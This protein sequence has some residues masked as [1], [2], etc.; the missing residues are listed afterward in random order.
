VFFSC[1]KEKQKASN[2]EAKNR[3]LEEELQLYKEALGFSND[4]I[5]IIVDSDFN[6]VFK[7]SLVDSK[8]DN[9]NRLIDDIRSGKNRVK[10][11]ECYANVIS[12]SLPNGNKIYN[13]KKDDNQ[14]DEETIQT[15]Q[16]NSI[17]EALLDTQRTF[18]SMLDELNSLKDYSLVVANESKDGLETA[19]VAT[20]R[21]QMLEVSM[22]EAVDSVKILYERSSEIS[23]MISLIE[24]IADQTNLLAL[25]AAI[26][27][28]RAGEY[29]RGFAVVA[30]EVRN[31][32][33][34]TQNATREITVVVNSIQQ[35][36]TKT[37]KSTEATGKI[38][39]ETVGSIT[40]LQERMEKFE[41]NASRTVFEVSHLSDIIFVTL[42]KVDHVIYKNNVYGL[43]HVKDGNFRPASHP[44]CRLGSW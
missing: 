14:A 35:E 37:Q 40:D 3:A 7:N 39:K 25:N 1:S 9:L 6:I 16:Q 30:D 42:A 19:Y 4:E 34:K 41:Q 32:A 5:I 29:G 20:K 43:L 13:I 15:L 26:E 2:L 24:D 28:S 27:A 44:N 36:T 17:K 21:M 22:Q 10:V 23:N 38:V 18:E 12:K 31:L 11:K 8:I 33:E